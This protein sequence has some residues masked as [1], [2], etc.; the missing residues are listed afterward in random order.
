MLLLA[1]LA[2]LVAWRVT[3]I[4]MPG[5][6][7]LVVWRVL[8]APY[9][10]AAAFGAAFIPLAVIFCVWRI[11]HSKDDRFMSV[12]KIII[13]AAIWLLVLLAWR[14]SGIF[15]SCDWVLWVWWAL[16]TQYLLAGGVIS[17]VLLVLTVLCIGKIKYRVDARTCEEKYANIEVSYLLRLIRFAYVYRD[18]EGASRIRIAGFS[19]GDEEPGK[20]KPKSASKRSSHDKKATKKSKR[21]R[22]KDA[23][24]SSEEEKKDR[25]NPLKQAKAVLT[26]PDRK[27]IM[28]LCFRC[29]GKFFKALKPKH[30]D[31][32]GVIGFDDP[33]TTGWAMGAYEAAAGITGL[34]HKI[35]L[36]GC[37]HEKA[38]DLAIQTHG[39]TRLWGLIWPFVW[40]YLQKPI[41]TV[42]HKHI[43]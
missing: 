31:I 28:N 10:L 22:D 25:P 5:G 42:L 37:Y 12:G 3:G 13:S 34:R 19:L 26:Y 15:M 2:L 17:F 1:V 18:G 36:V 23:G 8:V 7:V 38:M 6:W 21:T 27:I 43:F 24:T 32:Y 30:L 4:F 20:K 40:L 41:R 11:W 14:I 16:M 29:L 33:C 39:R 35:R 9:V